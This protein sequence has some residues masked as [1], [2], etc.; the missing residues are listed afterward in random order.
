MNKFQ[1]EK[2][3]DEL[4]EEA[5]PLI[6]FSYEKTANELLGLFRNL[7]KQYEEKDIQG[8]E[9]SYTMVVSMLDNRIG[10]SYREDMFVRYSNRR[11]SYESR[12][13]TL[14][15]QMMK[16]YLIVEKQKIKKMK[17]KMT[18]EE[19]KMKEKMNQTKT[20]VKQIRILD[21]ILLLLLDGEKTSQCINKEFPTGNT[22]HVVNLLTEKKLVIR[23]PPYIRGSRQHFKVKLTPEGKKLAEEM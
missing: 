17:E 13:D 15:E 1:M 10:L 19:Q 14:E 7:W 6:L 21:K 20:N 12:L 2:L 18:V 4:L 22:T 8:F 16:K 9:K 3:F 11:K 5:F 23:N